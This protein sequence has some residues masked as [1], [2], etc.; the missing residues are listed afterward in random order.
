MSVSEE[1]RGMS[2]RLLATRYRTIKTLAIQKACIVYEAVDTIE[3]KTVA[4]KVYNTHKLSP[5]QHVQLMREI[6]IHRS[7]DHKHIVKLYECL[8][9]EEYCVLV[10]EYCN[11]GNLYDFI[12]E[13]P[14]RMSE[15]EVI[16]NVL[17]PLSSALKYLHTKGIIHRDVKL[18]NVLIHHGKIK[19]GDFGVAIDTND[20]RPVTRAGT[21]T[22][23]SPEVLQCPLKKRP[24]ENKDNPLVGGYTPQVD[25]WST[26]VLLYECL[27]NASPY[28]S[29]SREETMR[30]IQ[31][32]S[33]PIFIVRDVSYRVMQMVHSCFAVDPMERPTAKDLLVFAWGYIFKVPMYKP[34]EFTSYSS[35]ESMMRGAR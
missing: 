31:N 27:N 6:K 7:I 5:M 33:L 9:I 18:D 11:G 32:A 17:I 29:K 19:L 20:E 4:L 14:K 10:L 16:K 22:Y 12:M 13:L 25:I 1:S 8:Y 2:E 28:A 15:K 23:L 34:I 30:L 21:L 3:G 35:S 24:E 26:G